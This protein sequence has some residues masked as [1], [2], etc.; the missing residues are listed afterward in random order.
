[1]YKTELHAHTSEV[2]RCARHNAKDMIERYISCGYTSL[3]ITDHFSSSTFGDL[4]FDTHKDMVKHFFKGYETALKVAEGRINVLLGMELRFHDSDNDYLVYGIDENFLLGCEGLL[5]YG[6]EKMH[7]YCSK[8]GAIILQAHP[9]RNGMK[10]TKPI[11]LDGIEAVNG[12]ERHDSRNSIAKAWGELF[13]HL[14]CVGGSDY[15]YPE[16]DPKQGILTDEPIITSEQ[17]VSLLK[18][19]KFKII[20]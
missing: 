1:M 9:F 6:I 18:N 2:S 19:R 10:I 3:V 12:N 4:Q 7:D 14:I 15:H 16:C 8:N 11:Y 17:L 20:E 5:D 13:P